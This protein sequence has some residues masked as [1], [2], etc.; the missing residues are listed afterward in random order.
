M[1]KNSLICFRA[2]KDLHISL[3]RIAKEDQRSV[4]AMIEMILTNHLKERK[5]I[6]AD[7]KEQ[8]QYPRKAISVPSI[9]NQTDNGQIG[10]GS[11]S[12]ISLSGVRILIPKDF[13]NNVQIEAQGSK[14]DIVFNLP[15]ENKP[16]KL[17]CESKSVSEAEDCIHVGA[18]FIDAGFQS[19]KTLQTYLM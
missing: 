15:M 7:I 1:K 3:A 12:E 5:S 2:S 18:A 4:S 19:Y 14:F 16:I 8:R 6:P 11:I 13:Q 17:S 10:M 9:I